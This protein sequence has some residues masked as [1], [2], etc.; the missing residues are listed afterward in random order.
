MRC[1]RSWTRFLDAG[2]PQR[3][4]RLRRSLSRPSSAGRVGRRIDWCLSPTSEAGTDPRLGGL[5]GVF[6]AIVKAP[7]GRLLTLHAERKQA[8]A[9][10]PLPRTD[11][12][13]TANPRMAQPSDLSGLRGRRPVTKASGLSPLQP[14]GHRYCFRAEGDQKRKSARGLKPAVTRL[15]LR[16]CI[17]L[18]RPGQSAQIPQRRAPAR[19]RRRLLLSRSG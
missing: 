17:S 5:G 19:G 10:A 18:A 16:G 11:A 4:W 12:C 9:D 14:P 6:A 1:P 15:E 13:R 7:E 8:G 3:R 2:T